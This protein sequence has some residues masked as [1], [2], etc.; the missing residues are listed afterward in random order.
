VPSTAAKPIVIGIVF[1]LAAW[2]LWGMRDVV[3][4]WAAQNVTANIDF[5]TTTERD[6]ARVTRAFE[7]ARQNTGADAILEPLPNQT[8]VRHTRVTVRAP[9]SVE[10]IAQAAAMAEAMTTAFSRDGEG[11]LSVDVRRRTRFPMAAPP[12]WVTR[13]ASPLRPRQFSASR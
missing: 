8:K 11:A 4:S 13:C 6:D 1:L 2:L 3:P 10:A 5:A 7:R 9:S 12:S